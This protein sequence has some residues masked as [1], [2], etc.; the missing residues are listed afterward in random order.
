MKGRHKAERKD[1][2]GRGGGGVGRKENGA[3]EEREGRKERHAFSY[4]SSLVRRASFLAL[5][6]RINLK[7]RNKEKGRKLMAAFILTSFL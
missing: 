7:H 3:E 2:K 1:R 4:L 5:W 6:E